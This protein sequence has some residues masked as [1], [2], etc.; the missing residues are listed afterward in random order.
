MKLKSK[1]TLPKRILISKQLEIKVLNSKKHAAELFALVDSNRTHLRK[2]LPWVDRTKSVK[3]SATFIKLV[4]KEWRTRVAFVYGIFFDGALIG[5]V[6]THEIDFLSRKTSF[7]YWLARDYC[8]R[9]ITT[10]CSEA[11]V[12]VLFEKLKLN[13]LEIRT[14]PKNI[15]SQRV[16]R[17]LGFKREAIL[18]QQEWLYDHFVDHVIFSKHARPRK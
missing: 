11:L 4:E 13:R 15:P 10:R 2:W 9:G 18:R 12:K 7:G 16:A 14:A 17:H 6:G 8:G 1:P 3:D 5:M